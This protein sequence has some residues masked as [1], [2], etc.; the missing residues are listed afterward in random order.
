MDA[1]SGD[2]DWS[3]SL[4][5]PEPSPELLETHM[6]KSYYGFTPNHPRSFFGTTASSPRLM[7]GRMS[8]VLLYRECS[9]PPHIAHLNLLRYVYLR[10]QQDF[11][12]IAAIIILL[13]DS[14]CRNKPEGT[15]DEL[16]FTFDGESQIMGARSRIS[17]LGLRA[18]QRQMGNREKKHPAEP[19]EKRAKRRIPLGLP[20][21]DWTRLCQSCWRGFQTLL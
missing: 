3:S 14:S 5:L 10:A 16:L 12:I 15:N 20:H 1:Y 6:V 18:W 2:S 9:N 17:S 4:A 7:H 13:P 21:V 19:T 11:N 8:R